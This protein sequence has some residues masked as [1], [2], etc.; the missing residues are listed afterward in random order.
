MRM[1]FRAREIM[2]GALPARA[3]RP[4]AAGFG[5]CPEVTRTGG[6]DEDE[7]ECGEVTR[8]PGPPSSDRLED[9]ALLRLQLRQT[10]SAERTA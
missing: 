5:L 1:S 3:F 6:D 10:L 9:L 7:S 4:G 2:I 8:P